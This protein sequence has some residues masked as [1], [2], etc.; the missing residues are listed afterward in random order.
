[1]VTGNV[2]SNGTDQPNRTASTV[3]VPRI[4]TC[5]PPFVT[6]VASAPMRAA[7]CEVTGIRKHGAAV[8]GNLHPAGIAGSQLLI[9]VAGTAQDRKRE[10]PQGDAERVGILHADCSR[11]DPVRKG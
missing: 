7:F 2:F 8:S 1:M 10:F 11:R 3:A 4:V 5:T 9:R 6:K